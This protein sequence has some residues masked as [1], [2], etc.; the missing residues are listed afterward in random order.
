MMKIVPQMPQPCHRGEMLCFQ[1]FV[2]MCGMCGAISSHYC[3][4]RDVFAGDCFAQCMKIVPQMVTT[5]TRR[6]F[7]SVFLLWHPCGMCGIEHK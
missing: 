1:G 4:L 6:C 2:T 3:A 7:C 5:V